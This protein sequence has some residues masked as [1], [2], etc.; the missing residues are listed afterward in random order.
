MNKIGW[1]IAYAIV[2]ALAGCGKP[3][4]TSVTGQELVT[5][6]KEAPYVSCEVLKERRDVL[7]RIASGPMAVNGKVVDGRGAKNALPA[8]ALALAASRAMARQHYAR[9]A[10]PEELEVQRKTCALFPDHCML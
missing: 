3:A 8:L 5:W 4:K 9:C 1:L 6:T 10:T 7:G 2:L